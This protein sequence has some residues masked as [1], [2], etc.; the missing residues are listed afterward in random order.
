M[1][2]LLAFL[3]ILV[4]AESAA[5][6]CSCI[7][8]PRDPALRQALARDARAGALALV[9]VEL[10]SPYA[11]PGRGERLRVRRTL[12]GRAPAVFSVERPR[13][14]SSAACDLEFQPGQRTLILL[15]PTRQPVNARGPVFR[16]SASC[17]SYLLN[18]AA[19]RAALIREWRRR[20]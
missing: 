20:R 12:A 1:R 6:A 7:M 5:L 16:I 13:E 2:R 3:L 18:D 17:T 8:A 11:G 14:P 10:V 15:Y 4:A 19:F 9:E